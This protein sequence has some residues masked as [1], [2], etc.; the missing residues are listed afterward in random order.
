MVPPNVHHNVVNTGI[1]PLR[2]YTVYAPPNH[3]DGRVQKT[4]ADADADQ[5]DKAFGDAVQ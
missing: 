5:A 3:I 4:K 1:E 2:I